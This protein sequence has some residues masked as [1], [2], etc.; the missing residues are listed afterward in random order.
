MDFLAPQ[1]FS[2]EFTQWNRSTYEIAMQRSGFEKVTWI[3]FAVSAEGIARQGGGL[4]GRAASQPKEYRLVCEEAALSCKAFRFMTRL[5]AVSDRP[6][7][8]PAV[9]AFALRPGLAADQPG[10]FLSP[11]AHPS[12]DRNTFA[13]GPF[14]AKQANL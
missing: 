8:S 11:I 14:T 6:F 9:A 7:H 3:P 1:K 13:N 2:I 12:P 5:R 10:P 4:L